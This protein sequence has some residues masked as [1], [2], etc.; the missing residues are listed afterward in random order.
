MKKSRRKD[1]FFPQRGVSNKSEELIEL[2]LKVLHGLAF[3]C[4]PL[5][6]GKE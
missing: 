6:G 3:P 5:E 2:I 1:I 4:E